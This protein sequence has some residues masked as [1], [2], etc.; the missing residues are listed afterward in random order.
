MIW[1]DQDAKD[2]L[3]DILRKQGYATYARIFQL[4]D[5]YYTDDP[6]VVAYMIPQ[7]AAIVMN[8][9]VKSEKMASV[10][11]RHEILHEYATHY[12]RQL[13]Y[14]KT[15]PGKKLP[16]G[17]NVIANIAGD[18]DISNIGYTDADKMTVR[19]M[20]LGDRVLRGLVTE[21]DHAD[22]VNLTFEEMYEKLLDE[23]EKDQEKA[24]KQMNELSDLDPDMLDKLQKEIDDLID[25]AEQAEKNNTSSS[26]QAGDKDGEKKDGNSKVTNVN[27]KQ[28]EEGKESKEGKEILDKAQQQLDNIK[29][30]TDELNQKP[31]DNNAESKIRADIAARARQLKDLLGSK[32][33]KNR[34]TGE[35]DKNIEKERISKIERQAKRA[36][37]SGLERFKLSLTRFIKNEVVEREETSFSKLYTP[38]LF[39]DMYTPGRD[40]VEGPVPLINVYHDVSGSFSDPAKT[41]GAL[42]AMDTLREYVRKG[43]I[44][45][46]SYYVTDRVYTY[47]NKPTSGW[48]ASGEAIIQHVKATH[49]ANVVV[50]TDSDADDCTSSVTVPGAVWLLFYDATAPSLIDHLRGRKE[51]R[52]YMIDYK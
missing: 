46:Q 13:E 34:L 40:F 15:H 29:D 32:A 12:E 38:H 14:Q 11:V 4:F 50:I 3:T 43:Q 36:Q 16:S 28:S 37:S 7:K 24:Q 22:W 39:R 49:P 44:R 23:Q 17:S 27:P 45:L 51:N 10:L 30:K 9:E 52:Y 6:N 35:V 5:F 19:N 42:R 20:M 25:Q 8:S 48:G 41:E 31:F 47:D 18:Y 33:I 26:S 21:D 2:Q 1:L